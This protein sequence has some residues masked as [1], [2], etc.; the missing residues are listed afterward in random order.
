[1]GT[2]GLIVGSR[3]FRRLSSTL[4]RSSFKGGRLQGRSQG[5][6][7]RLRSQTAQEGGSQGHADNVRVDG[8]AQPL[9]AVPGAGCG[10]RLVAEKNKNRSYAD[11]RW[12]WHETHGKKGSGDKAERRREKARSVRAWQGRKA[13]RWGDPV[14]F[15]MNKVNRGRQEILV[16]LWQGTRPL[17][18]A[19]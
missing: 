5:N 15:K 14:P 18:R 7:T 4:L 10:S 13:R 12:K 1:M 6:E 17:L 11:L 9:R 3:H 2:A 19:S 8:A 16:N